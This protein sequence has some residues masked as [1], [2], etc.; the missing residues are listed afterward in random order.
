MPF[1]KG[2][3]MAILTVNDLNKSYGD[4]VVLS[5]VTF[6]INKNDKVAIIGDNGEGKTTLLKI[7]TK[8]L[9]SDSG[10][11]RF[12]T[13]TTIGYLSQ[14]VFS[15]LD[16]TLYKEM[17]EVYSP[18]IKIK[19]ELDELANNITINYSEENVLKFTNLE[20]KYHDLGGYQYNVNIEMLLNKFGFDVTYY[21]RTIRSLSGG[22][23]TRASLVKLLLNNPNVLLLD[24]PTNHLDLIM[25]E[26]LEK[27]L[28]TYSGTVIIVSHDR[29][30][31]D[32]FANKI[33][34][35]ENHE[36][37]LFNCNYDNY[38]KTKTMRYEQQL[39]QYRLQEKEIHR[40]E[41][42][43][44]K[45]RPKPTKTSFAASLEK[46]LDKMVKIEKPKESKRTIKAHFDTN[47][48]N[49][50]IMHSCVDLTF[51]YSDKPLTEPFSLDIYNQDKICIM[52]QNGCGKSTL[53]QCI[54]NN[55]HKISGRNDNL[56]DYSYFY[57]DQ[58][59]E[60]LNPD[61]T[62]FS[63]IQD[64]FPLMTNTEVRNLL[65]RFLFYEDDAFKLVSNLSGGEKVRLVFALITLR[66][67]EVLFLDEP[68]N[69]LDFSTKQ[70]VA[71]ILEEY[72]GTI[73]MVSHD[74]YFINRIA[75]K[76]V[77]IQ[78]KSFIIENGNYEDFTLLHKIEANAFKTTK[79]E[80]K[81]KEKPKTN[82]TK[83]NKNEITKIEQEINQIEKEI[84]LRQ[85]KISDT[86]TQYRWDEYK[87]MAKEIEDLET[88]LNE[89]LVKLESLE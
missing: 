85:D 8:E 30:F 28:K 22:E 43:I 67:Y 1:F 72:P 84:K 80:N 82:K 10:T 32:N 58:N 14:E 79:K 20:T 9:S 50:V 51:G 13:N 34:A 66:K 38:C 81:N 27:Y 11:F 48:S 5:H 64:E 60:V 35:I 86:T 23:R 53:I 63:T 2:E 44:R 16:N 52:G 75:N 36:A 19:K 21:N 88:T 29:T 56:R 25:I 71:D 89:L 24:E 61:K 4:K 83:S 12:E 17:E 65:G 73:V 46:K 39:K 78:N 49:R 59:Q 33:L 76:I 68:T 18:L 45:F 37:E 69:H 62:L 15:N 57:F 3:N 70:V 47:L 41:M 54:M 6:A 87:Q 31:I 77:Y 26:L 40:Y 42:L 74:R 7:L 55:K